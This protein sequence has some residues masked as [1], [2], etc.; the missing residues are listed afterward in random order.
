MPLKYFELQPVEI[1]DP[2]PGEVRIATAAVLDCG[3]CGGMIDGMGGPGYGAVCVQCADV[4]FRGQA[5]GAIKWSRND[6][7]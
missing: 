4:V 1:P 6:G 3:L 5:V 7:S 2:E